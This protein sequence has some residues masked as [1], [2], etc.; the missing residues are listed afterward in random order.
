MLRR[1]LGLR[2]FDMGMIMLVC[3]AGCR[4][5]GDAT[6]AGDPTAGG[7]SLQ[8]CR[9]LPEAAAAQWVEGTSEPPTGQ[10]TPA[11]MATAGAR[12]W[13]LAL[14][15][16]AVT[17]PD[18][19]LAA[20]PTAMSLALGMTERLYANAGCGAS[21][22]SRMHYAEEGDALHQTLG[23]SLR[24][25]EE[26]SLPASEDE[27]PVIV[28]LTASIW[29]ITG[30]REPE[31]LYGAALHRV[32]GDLAASRT[33]M[34]CVIEAQSR[35]LLVDF[36]PTTIPASDTTSI[37]LDVAY[38]QAPWA[39]GLQDRGMQPF[40]RDDGSVV[41][42]PAMGEDV[43]AGWYEDEQ[44]TAVDVPLRGG[45]L[46]VLFVLPAAAG[47]LGA[48][49]ASLDGPTLAAAR[50]SMARGPVGLRMPKV[51]I[52]NETIDYYEPL[53]FDCEPFTLR[54]VLHG[55][56]VQMDEN[57][58]KAAAAGAAESWDSGGPEGSYAVLDRPFLFFVYDESTEFVL[59]SG[60]F[61]G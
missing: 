28:S 2:C 5:D 61:A 35:G 23:A 46:S 8:V 42:L 51:D 58:V 10:S 36:L 29:D 6:T 59:S 25:L 56:A 9:E 18:R 19:S 50:A 31:P 43:A 1:M 12:T 32:S 13:E 17:E 34:N 47:D 49:T 38:L 27:A 11:R 33:V 3:L 4:A 44:L 7:Y 22:R 39:Q 40:T 24:T 26:R 15:L 37:D 16:L 30:E 60:R 20:S 41:Q 53:E 57:G 45:A 52:P 14:D 54:T 48:F 21:I 55:A